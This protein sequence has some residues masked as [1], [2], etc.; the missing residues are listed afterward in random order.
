MVWNKKTAVTLWAV[1]VLAL[2]PVAGAS[3][4][5]GGDV[6]GAGATDLIKTDVATIRSRQQYE[7]VRPGTGSAIAVDFETAKNWH[8]YAS[9]KTAPAQANLK[10]KASA[11][12]YIKFSN[13]IL[14]RPQM[15][16]D[17]STGV[18]LEVFSGSFTVYI[19]FEIEDVSPPESAETVEIAIE[20]AVCSDVQCR[21][22]DFGRLKTTIRI[23]TEAAMQQAAFGLPDYGQEKSRIDTSSNAAQ[24]WADYSMLAA[25][26]LALLA[27][28]SLNIMPCVWPVLPVI[29]MRL[30]EQAKQG[31]EKS[32]A[33]GAAFCGGILLFFATLAAANII[34]KVFYGTSLQWADQFR[35]PVIVAAMALLLIVLALFMFGLF[36]ISIPSSVAAKSGQGKGLAG[37]A[38]MGFLAAILITPCSFGILAAAFAW[39]QTQPIVTGTAAIMVIGAGMSL[40]YAVLV[41][42]PALLKSLPRGGRWLE[43][44]KQSI[45]FLLLVIAVKFIAALPQE[46]RIDVIYF[47]LVLSF[48]VWMWGGWVSFDTAILRKL[49][50]RLAAVGL[51][52]T[53]GVMFL[54]PPSKQLIEWQPYS[55]ESVKKA[56]QEQRPVLIK[57]TAE[58]CLNCKT[59]EKIVYGRKDI[60]ELI[61]RKNVLAVRADT[62]LMDNPATAALKNIYHEPAVPVSVLLAPGEKVF[63]MEGYIICQ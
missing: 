48:C 18:K 53:A 23:S 22:P 33:L 49:A 37:S 14:P 10:L 35:N 1:Y 9:E 24:P 12:K 28:L 56:V 61:R 32:A 27:G 3:K 43:I 25:M 51:A 7:F 36:T 44:F 39:A 20:G 57:F 46:R 55:A 58:W 21:M 30:V 2:G 40:P 5:N 47:A 50:I 29:V 31:K 38:A 6:T 15:Y 26:A 45:G 13:P 60:A 19:P 54:S 8:F 62:T 34:L 59:A 42:M 4:G 41:S 63:Q 17:K 52:A 11:G 16:F